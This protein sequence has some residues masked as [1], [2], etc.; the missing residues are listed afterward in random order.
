MTEKSPEMTLYINRP[1]TD[2]LSAG[3]ANNFIITN[4]D[5][6]QLKP[7]YRQRTRKK[8][9]AADSPCCS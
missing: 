4:D 8:Y 7:G 1:A 6:L 2:A 9:Q 3:A 5:S